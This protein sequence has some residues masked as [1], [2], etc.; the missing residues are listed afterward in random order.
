MKIE[1]LKFTDE[2]LPEAGILLADRHARNRRAFPLLPTRFEDIQV[3]TKEI[4][5]LW[6][7]RLKNGYAALRNGK[8]IAYLIGEFSVQPWARSG[9]VYLPGYALAEGESKEIIKDLYALLGEDWVRKGVFSHNLYISANDSDVTDGLFEI[10]FGQERIDTLLD[11]NTLDIPKLDPPEGMIVRPAEKGDEARLKSIS[12]VMM[13]ALGSAPYW[14]PTAP[15][16]YLDL[17]DGWSELATDKE[18]SAV[19]MAIENEQALGTVGFRPVDEDDPQ[20]LMSPNTIYMGAAVT[21]P[22]ARGRGVATILTWSG[23]DKARKDGFELCY[24]NWISPN[25]LAARF[26][27]RFGFTEVSYRLSKQIN[28]KITWAKDV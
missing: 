26:W 14:L 4:E 24:T 2:M 28:P 1:F 16:T 8:M 6:Q 5:N 10:G 25:L 3:A 27:P 22:E 18:W 7:K 20:M 21:K 12:H 19:W 17:E 15:E 23:F 9:Y 13:N 11:L